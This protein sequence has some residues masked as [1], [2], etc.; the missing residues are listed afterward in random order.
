MRRLALNSALRPHHTNLL[1][2]STLAVNKHGS[3]AF[4]EAAQ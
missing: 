4:D 2:V 3:G 1:R